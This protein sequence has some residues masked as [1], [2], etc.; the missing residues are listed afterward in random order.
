MT[1]ELKGAKKKYE[2]SEGGVERP[3]CSIVFSNPDDGFSEP[4]PTD[5][6]LRAARAKMGR[7]VRESADDPRAFYLWKRDDPLATMVKEDGGDGGEWTRR[8]D[9]VSRTSSGVWTRVWVHHVVRKCAIPPKTRSALHLVPSSSFHVSPPTR[10]HPPSCFMLCLFLPHDQVLPSGL[11]CTS[12]S[13]V[14]SIWIVYASLGMP[15]VRTTRNA[16]CSK[17]HA[18]C[19]AHF[20]S[21]ICLYW[22]RL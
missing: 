7:C 1:G 21:S 8:D 5:E 11:R 20:R 22:G 18:F 16:C 14:E 13:P 17:L 12:N 4:S 10:L 3:I 9:E 15:Q 19:M 2:R 6:R